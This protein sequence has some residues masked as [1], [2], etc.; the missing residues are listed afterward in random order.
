MASRK[1]PKRKPL[2][3]L[4]DVLVERAGALSLLLVV[5]GIAGFAALPLLER[6]ISFDENALLAGSAR[7]TIRCAADA[8]PSPT[9]QLGIRGESEREAPPCTPPPPPAT[10]RS[11]S[12]DAFAAATALAGA[13]TP[14]FQTPAYLDRLESALTA[15]GLEVYRQPFAVRPP[16]RPGAELRCGRLHAILRSPRGDGKEG[17]VLVTPVN[18]QPFSTGGLLVGFGF[19]W[20]W[21]GLVL[22]RRSRCFSGR[23]AT[24]PPAHP[25][26]PKPSRLQPDRRRRR[27][28]RLPRP[29][30]AAP[31]ARR[32]LAGQ[33]RRVAG[34]GRELR[35]GRRR[36][37]L[38]GGVPADG[39]L[40]WGFGG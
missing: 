26:Q 27:A 7:P 9:G 32:P 22:A 24:A 16:G 20:F 1:A 19:G 18:L 35:A 36:G 10:R 21:F 14:H 15:A 39:T 30:A 29:R 37:G 33:G 3:R 31:P 13:L 40:S 5:A 4:L 28:R 2:D 8:N 17:V 12:P 38:G 6:N 25:Q 34:G 23:A 11:H